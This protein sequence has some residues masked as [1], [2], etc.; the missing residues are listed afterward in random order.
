MQCSCILFTAYHGK[1]PGDSQEG[2]EIIVDLVR[3]KGSAKGKEFLRFLLLGKDCY[4][5]VKE[6]L[7]KAVLNIEEWKEVTQST[8]F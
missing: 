5:L 7:E 4:E 2:A 8:D 6:E 1:Q 3:G